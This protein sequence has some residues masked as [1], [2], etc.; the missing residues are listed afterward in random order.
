MVMASSRR[1]AASPPDAVDRSRRRRR[2]LSRRALVATATATVG[3]QLLG[4]ADAYHRAPCKKLSDRRQFQF[5][6]CYVPNLSDDLYLKRASFVM[7][8]DAATGYL[9]VNGNGED[10]SSGGGSDGGQYNK[11]Y[12]GMDD[13]NNADYMQG[14]GGG[15]YRQNNWSPSRWTSVSTRLLSLYGKTQV[16]TVYDQLNDGA[17]AL[18][19]RPKIYNN[20][21]IGF[22]H[23]S[24]IEVPLTSITLGGLLEDAK[25]WCND[26]PKELVIIFHSELVHEAGYYGLNGQ[27][28]ME[29]DDDYETDDDGNNDDGNDGGEDEGADNGEEEAN[30]ADNEEEEVNDANEE[31]EDAD[32]AEDQEEGG[33]RRRL[34]QSY[35]Y[36]YAGIAKMKEVYAEAEVP[37]YPCDKLSGLTVAEAME[38]ADLSKTG[39]KGYLLAVDRHDMYAS[40]CGKANWAQ[41]QLVTCHSRYYEDNKEEGGEHEGGNNRNNRQS[42]IHCTDTRGTGVSKLSA[43]QSYV[44][45]STNGE[46]SDDSGELGPPYDESYYPFNQIQGFWQVDSTS[47]QIGIMHASNLLDD[48]RRSNVNEE[49]VKMAYSGE[50]NAISIFALDNVALNGNAMFSVLRNACGQSVQ[51]YNGDDLPCGKNLV[52]PNMHVYHK[53]PLVWNIVLF[54]VYGALVAMV[55]IMLFQAFRLRNEGPQEHRLVC[56]GHVV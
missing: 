26:N 19:L 25:Q 3:M 28:Y 40:F 7:A 22:H 10:G 9:N 33:G 34:D 13:M 23:G 55:S 35:E 49:M 15:E 17:R 36:T 30:D 6:D 12:D 21:T 45:A 16:G 18:D 1:A 38:L 11:E 14:E 52:M 54:V 5:S 53:L 29:T 8:H 24:L 50:F 46:A 44:R 47:V 4:T 20:G 37:Y 27:V 2:P 39:G 43:L 31:D 51:Q 48:N 42:Y 56:H 41:D 32:Q